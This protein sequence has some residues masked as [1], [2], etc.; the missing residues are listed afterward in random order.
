MRAK[1]T[2]KNTLVLTATSKKDGK[3]LKD[4]FDDLRLGRKQLAAAATHLGTELTLE[5][6]EVSKE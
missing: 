5:M 3:F 6:Q 2:D 4:A 1:L